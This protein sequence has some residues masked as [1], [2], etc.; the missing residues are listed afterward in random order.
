MLL[1]PVLFPSRWRMAYVYHINKENPLIFLTYLIDPIRMLF[2]L[3]K[4]FYSILYD[5]NGFFDRLF[6]YAGSIVL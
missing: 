6:R 3:K 4:I 2:L 1:I 5:M